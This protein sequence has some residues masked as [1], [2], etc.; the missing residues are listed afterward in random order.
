MR[1]QAINSSSLRIAVRKNYSLLLVKISLFAFASVAIAVKHLAVVGVGSATFTPWR[2]VVG[3]AWWWTGV[4]ITPNT[5]LRSRLY[6]RRTTW[7]LCFFIFVS[8]DILGAV[9]RIIFWMLAW[10]LALYAVALT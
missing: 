5:R 6:L 7:Y 1:K 8:L 3:F 4:L 10:S 2:D 9:E